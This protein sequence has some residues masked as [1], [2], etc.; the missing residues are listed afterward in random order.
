MRCFAAA[1]VLFALAGHCFADPSGPAA[2]EI[3]NTT[4]RED[5]G[6]TMTSRPCPPSNMGAK[7]LIPITGAGSSWAVLGLVR[8]AE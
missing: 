2:A 5:G 3:R 1:F 6:W 7:N 8:S 4:Q